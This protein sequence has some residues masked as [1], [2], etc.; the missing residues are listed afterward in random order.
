MRITAPLDKVEEARPL[1]EAGADELYCGVSHPGWARVPGSPNLRFRSGANLKSFEE[2][3]AVTSAASGLGV[4]VLF[5][6]NAACHFAETSRLALEDMDRAA[7]SGV[8]GFIISDQHLL[9]EARRRYPDRALTASSF[10]NCFNSES[11]ALAAELGAGRLVLPRDLTLEETAKV[12]NKLKEKAPGLRLEAFVQN[13]TCRN[14]NGYC[15]C[16]VP[17]GRFPGGWRTPLRSLAAMWPGLFP[18]YF[19]APKTREERFSAEPPCLMPYRARLS[20][21]LQK[22][23]RTIENFRM[24]EERVLGCAACGIFHFKRLGIEYLKIVGRGL[25][26]THKVQDVKFLA[27]LRGILDECSEDFEVFSK[28]ARVLRENIY[29]SPCMPT[30]CHYPCMLKARAGERR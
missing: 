15:R 4:P 24:G 26:T 14:V 18:G 12:C 3:R 23:E 1:I 8:N 22:S 6:L 21:V 11:G 17:M 10:C 7:A 28:R 5:T 25:P 2:L 16:H 13:I 20:G 29:G 19:T 9:A 30:D 27:G